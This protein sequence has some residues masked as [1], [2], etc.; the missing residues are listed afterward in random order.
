MI[1]T[2]GICLPYA[3]KYYTWYRVHIHTLNTFVSST[4]YTFEDD[5]ARNMI[6]TRGICLPYATKYYTWYRVHI[7]TLNIFVSSTVYTFEGDIARNLIPT[8]EI[9]FPYA[10]KYYTWY[11]VHIHMLNIV[12]SSTV[13]I[14]C[15]YELHCLWIEFPLGPRVSSSPS[16]YAPIKCICMY[17]YRM[18]KCGISHLMLA[19]GWYWLLGDTGFWVI[20]TKCFGWYQVVLKLGASPLSPM[21]LPGTQWQL[22]WAYQRTARQ[23]GSPWGSKRPTLPHFISYDMPCKGG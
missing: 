18:C 11:R 15:L 22:G 7:H 2:R 6:P 10:S 19:F 12:V 1:P 4:V 8:R 3:T 17:L 16:V 21:G 23:G 9:C 14:L 20:D 13:Y 5:I